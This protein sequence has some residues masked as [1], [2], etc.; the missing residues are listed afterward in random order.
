MNLR[1]IERAKNI[2]E[3][4]YNI[5]GKIIVL[6]GRIPKYTRTT[7]IKKIHELGGTV[8]DK[9]NSYTNIVVYTTLNS[10]KYRAAVRFSKWNQSDVVL[11]K[12]DDFV[13]NYLKLEGE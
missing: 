8:S 12:G 6:T 1:N 4:K 13:K 5:S 9:V 3:Q 10:E 7:I 11:V 2:K